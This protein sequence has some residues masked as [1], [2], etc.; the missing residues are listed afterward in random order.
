MDIGRRRPTSRVVLEKLDRLSRRVEQRYPR[1][2]IFRK[3]IRLK[4]STVSL[5]LGIVLLFPCLVIIVIIILFARHPDS[6]GMMM[7]P[8]G[9]PPSIRYV[10]LPCLSES[11]C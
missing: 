11:L 10:Q 7:M 3:R 2:A 9:T 8:G 4:N 6:D 5:P 1:A